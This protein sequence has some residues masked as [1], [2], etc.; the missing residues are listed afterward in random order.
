MLPLRLVIDTNVV[1]SAA[2]NPD[3]HS[4]LLSFSPLPSPPY[5]TYVRLQLLQLIKN[6][7]NLHAKA[8][9]VGYSPRMA[10]AICNRGNVIADCVAHFLRQE[11][12]FGKLLPGSH[13]TVGYVDDMLP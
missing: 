2:L 11:I 4:V 10:N 13:G 12:S 8:H 7:K 9:W 5:S 1:V 3:G 6:Y